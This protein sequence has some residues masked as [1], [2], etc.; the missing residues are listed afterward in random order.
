[1]TKIKDSKQLESLRTKYEE[2][3]NNMLHYEEREAE[4][5]IQN[6]SKQVDL[7]DIR[8]Y[9]IS[10]FKSYLK[11]PYPYIALV[12]G[13]MVPVAMFLFIMMLP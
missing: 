13:T 4:M 12:V 2:T 8:K 6:I 3:W 1:M 10:E 7:H 9:G 11:T 5:I